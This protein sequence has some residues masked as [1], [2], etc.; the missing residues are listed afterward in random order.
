MEKEQIEKLKRGIESIIPENG[1]EQ[2]LHWRKKK[3]VR[4]LL[5]LVWTRRLRIYI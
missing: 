5:N 2:N 3:I 4:W 1:L